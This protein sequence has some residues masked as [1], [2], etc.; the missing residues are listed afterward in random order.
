MS[1]TL[2]VFV[3]WDSREDI[4]YQICRHS[5]LRRAS[6]HVSVIPM[7]QRALAALG[8]YRRARDP[9]ASTEFAYTRFLV[10]YLMG[11]QGWALFCDCDFLWLDDVS[12]LLAHADN[13]YAAMC[14]QHDHRPT[15]TWKMDGA[16]QS[17]Y[18]R[19]NWSSLVLY[20]CGHP[21][22]AALTPDIVNGESGAYLHRLQWLD[23]ALIGALP[24]RWNWLEGWSAKPELG[25]PS[26]VHYTRGGP[27]FKDWRDVAYAEHWLA[28]RDDWHAQRVAQGAP[29]ARIASSWSIDQPEIFAGTH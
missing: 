15:E 2:K 9:L 20:N 8:L 28:E 16:R 25:V 12:K 4:A 6:Q 10:P 3:G 1:D 22:N 24:E 27:W 26:A 5:L 14:V 7:R 29:D 21:A 11:Y 23:D 13:N 19:K 18:P 17:V